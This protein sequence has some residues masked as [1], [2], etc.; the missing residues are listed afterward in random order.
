MGLDRR[1]S[2]SLRRSAGGIQ[3][4]GQRHHLWSGI[5]RHFP[6]DTR[7]Q[8]DSVH[9]LPDAVG[10]CCGTGL[11]GVFPGCR[12]DPVCPHGGPCGS[13]G[14]R[15]GAVG[16]WFERQQH[17]L[18]GDDGGC[19]DRG[20]QVADG[21]HA[22]C[23][24]RPGEHHHDPVGW[25]PAAAIAL[26]LQL[27]GLIS[28]RFRRLDGKLVACS[29]DP[30]AGSVSPGRAGRAILAKPG[31]RVPFSWIS[32]VRGG[33]LLPAAGT[34]HGFAI[35]A[36]L[37][38][39]WPQRKR[40]TGEPGVERDDGRH[41]DRLA[42]HAQDGEVDRPRASLGDWRH[43]LHVVSAADFIRRIDVV[44]DPLGRAGRL[45]YG[46]HQRQPV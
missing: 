40:C 7:G 38:G 20:R 14:A 19:S 21:Q 33:F 44:A 4:P 22:L 23:R 29:P 11:P 31:Q 42:A 36:D 46:G 28:D 26:S 30:R 18:P 24:V 15:V 39:A 17:R 35:A 32:E 6:A 25:S 10:D 1:I 13:H 45:V 27:P 41:G 9:R 8:A 2:A 12:A 43:R 3:L 5:D 37:L 34:R 16:L